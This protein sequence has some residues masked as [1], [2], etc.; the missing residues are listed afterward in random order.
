[1]NIVLFAGAVYHEDDVSNDMWAFDVV[2]REWREI[3]IDG[4]KPSVR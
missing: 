3:D 2:T 1:M 4:M